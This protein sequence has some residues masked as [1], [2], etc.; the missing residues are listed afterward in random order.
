[1]QDEIRISLMATR[2]VME[3]MLA[4]SMLQQQLV[5]A[6]DCC[7]N[8][9]KSGGKLMFVGNGGSAAE[10]QH[11]SAE[12]VGRFLQER[13]PLPSIAL[14]TDTSAVTAIGN[15]YGYEHVFSRQVQALG[16]KGDV[17][18]AMSTSGRSK[19]IV[20]A[21]QAAR[22]AGISTIGLTGIHPRDMVEL[23]DVSLKVPSSHTPQIQ[24]GHLVLGHLLCGM[25]EKQ[26]LS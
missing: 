8:A 21:M 9:L 26:L 11:F 1:M 10:A 2:Q 12:M 13:K 23:A 25:V 17:L 16:R 20:M 3:D 5:K 4:D 18:I 14:T 24:E 19:N 22:S 7:V 6:V 15:D